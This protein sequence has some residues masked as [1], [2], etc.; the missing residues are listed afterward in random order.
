LLL[1]E[2]KAIGRTDAY[3]RVIHQ[4]LNR[5][6]LED[7]GFVNNTGKYHVPRF[8]L[9]DFARNWWT[10][11]VDFAYKKKTRFG[12]G[13]AIRNIKLRF[14]RKLIYVSGLLTCYGCH[15][16]LDDFKTK[17]ICPGAGSAADCISCLSERLNRTP[18]EILADAFLHL[19]H[20]DGEAKKTI[21]AY[22]GF[23]GI[24]TNEA[25]RKCLEDL[26]SDSYDNEIFDHARK[27]SHDFR[28]GLMD[29]FFDQMS[30]MLELTRNYGVF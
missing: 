2:S 12:K 26:D 16:K 9:N 28:D 4:V 22:E 1:L 13:A 30:E 23:L 7:D 19:P 6:V 8:L 11:A 21:D 15:I 5:Y 25:S 27:L 17:G 29:L 10:M 18:I 24:L 20:L 14:S 3:E